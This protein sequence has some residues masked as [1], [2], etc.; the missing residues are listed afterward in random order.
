MDNANQMDV[1]SDAFR[2]IL[3]RRDGR[4]GEVE[5]ISSARMKMLNNALIREFPVNAALQVVAVRRDQLLDE[6]QPRIP[7]ELRAFL[8]RRT[9]SIS[10]AEG[11][12]GRFGFNLLNLFQSPVQ[13]TI[14]I[15]LA[16]IAGL[17]YF[18]ALGLPK[19]NVTRNN[20]P[21]GHQLSG[22]TR[23]TLPDESIVG[24]SYQ[25]PNVGSPAPER[26][27][28]ALNDLQR[29]PAPRDQF[30]LRVTASDL[31]CLRTVFLTAN[32]AES[33]DQLLGVRLDL[34]VQPI[35]FDGDIVGT[36]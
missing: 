8:R 24:Q 20:L 26:V 27:G 21:L 17:L 12:S 4:L 5:R 36:P 15:A 1:F 35:F 10:N 22:K 14:V 30:N 6:G 11:R 18:G 16:A 13:A 9:K 25:I 19:T 23:K 34:P 7:A 33:P 28:P 3:V 2:E 31:V 29:I 32:R